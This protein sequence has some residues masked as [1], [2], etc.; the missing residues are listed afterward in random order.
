MGYTGGVYL[1][2]SR[3]FSVCSALFGLL[4]FRFW[5]LLENAVQVSSGLRNKQ[6]ESQYLIL[7]VSSCTMVDY[8][9]PAYFYQHY[10]NDDKTNMAT[11]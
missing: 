2:R 4:H 11:I 9:M 3:M 6:K 1:L 7:P 5:H 8:A 10:I